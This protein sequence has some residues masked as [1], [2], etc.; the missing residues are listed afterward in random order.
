MYAVD[1]TLEGVAPILFS[2][3]VTDLEA[4]VTGQKITPTQRV[5]EA[6]QKVYR[7]GEGLYFPA[8]NLKRAIV[9][10]CGAANLK[11][12]RKSLKPMVMA[13]VF[14]EPEPLFGTDKFD[15]MHEATGKRPARTGGAVL[16]RRPALS[17]G[18]HLDFRLNVVVDR[19]HP[20]TLRVSLEH[21]GL[22]IGLGS[23]RPEYG[24][25]IVR[26]FEVATD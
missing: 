14:P 6:E 12:G 20:E 9:D 16:I 22:L 23:W 26:E 19:L 2:R 7:N 3:W 13:S 24:R 1:V 4:P 11:D 17:T 5:E 18:W 25:F 21:A 8:W 15:F 10:G